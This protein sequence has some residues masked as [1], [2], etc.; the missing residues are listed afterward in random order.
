MLGLGIFSPCLKR[1]AWQTDGFYH[2]QKVK[3]LPGALID[4]DVGVE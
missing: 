2:I 4:H 1:T 3:V